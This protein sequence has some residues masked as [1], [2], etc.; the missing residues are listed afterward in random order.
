M[1]H[2]VCPHIIGLMFV[3]SKTIKMSIFLEV[4]QVLRTGS[5]CVR[6]VLFCKLTPDLT[7][8][9]NFYFNFNIRKYVLIVCPLLS[10]VGLKE[11]HNLGLYNP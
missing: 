11:Q 8:W 4:K 10:G 5:S 1:T 9:F 3:C 7:D 6:C 2:K